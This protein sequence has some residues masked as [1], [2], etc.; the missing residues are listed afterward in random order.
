MTR[1][2]KKQGNP[3][4]PLKGQ[5]KTCPRAEKPSMNSITPQWDMT[6]TLSTSK[7][8]QIGGYSNNVGPFFATYK[9]FLHALNMNSMKLAV[10]SHSLFWSIHS[11]DESKRG[12]VFAFIFD[13][14]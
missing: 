1:R 9:F 6:H 5:Q 12:N 2:T 13:V 4:Q 3:S 11:K 7:D 10:P 14:N 8:I